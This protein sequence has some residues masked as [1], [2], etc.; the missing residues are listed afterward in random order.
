MGDYP[1]ART[2]RRKAGTEEIPGL[3]PPPF[4]VLGVSMTDVTR[5]FEISKV[6]EEKRM[7]YG[8][9]T[10][11]AVDAD[12]DIIDLETVKALMPEY[13]KH[14]AL[15]E[16][17]QPNVAGSVT[18]WDKDDEK[19]LPIGAHVTDEQ[20]WAKVKAGDYRG[21]SIRGPL[22]KREGKRV[23]LKSI[24]EFSLVDKPCNPETEIAVA[25][26]EG[27]AVDETKDSF[28][29]RQQDPDAFQAD[30]FRTI[31]IGKEIKAVVGK[32]PG[33]ESMEV[34][35]FIFPKEKWTEAE[36][37][38]WVEAHNKPKTKED[39]MDGQKLAGLLKEAAD[40]MKEA[41]DAHKAFHAAKEEAAKM[42]A[43]KVYHGGFG[44]VHKALGAMV[45]EAGADIQLPEFH[46]EP[47]GDEGKPTVEPQKEDAH[48]GMGFSATDVQKMVAAAVAEA[49]KATA[50]EIAKALKAEPAPTK[51]AI[52]AIDKDGSI[53]K[54]EGAEGEKG[55]PE[56]ATATDVIKFIQHG[57]D[58]ARVGKILG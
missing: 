17:H 31:A 34:Q 27:L 46:G 56:S 23:F 51:T 48:K 28:R 45:K 47:D 22:A 54:R 20:A 50:A 1:K 3:L 26:A 49:S 37:R 44:K 12:G 42:D 57:G 18:E 10:T 58:P 5:F 9:G 29:F 53:A 4:F 36:A 24:R 43:H 40:G 21:F 15:W 11:E 7:V 52:F 6:D 55:L 2:T 33:N 16:M 32:K 38:A 25:K 19:G 35:S 41:M 39:A 30:S 8:Y 14:P 13:M